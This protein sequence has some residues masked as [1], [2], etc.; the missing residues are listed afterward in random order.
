[1]IDD[2]MLLRVLV[3]AA[4]AA[5]RSLWRQ[6]ARH[7]PVPIEV[8]EAE[9]PAEAAALLQRGGADVVLVCAEL[10]GARDLVT[11]AQ[12][13]SSMP[14]VVLVLPHERIIRIG[15]S[16]GTVLRPT[17]PDQA[18]DILNNAVRARMPLR[19]MIV[20]D[21]ATMRSLVRKI[22]SAT[23]FKLMVEEVAEGVAAL[24]RMKSGAVDLVFLDHNMP[25]LS[26][27]ET[28]TE[29]RREMPHVA[30]VMMTSQMEPAVIAKAKASGVAG[31]LKK[32]FYPK[33]VNEVLARHYGLRI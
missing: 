10:V 20:D 7:A 14:L 4:G 21:S 8:L 31:F 22:L 30:V 1:M 11:A 12:K 5:E 26:G 2:L 3:A 18:R 16:I 29:I 23:H 32:P 28:L 33:D 6:A 9:T 13:H 25:G 24:A 15:D 27:I 19:A 17:H